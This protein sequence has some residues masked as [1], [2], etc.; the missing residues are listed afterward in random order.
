[1][2]V[3]KRKKNKNYTVLSNYHLRDKNLSLKAKGLLSI[4]LG[5]PEKWDYSTSGLETLSNDGNASVRSALQE[6][7]KH[8]YLNRDKIRDDKGRV[9]DWEYTVYENPNDNKEEEKETPHVEIPHVDNQAQ[10]NTKELNTKELK[11]YDK[12]NNSNEL[13]SLSK[14]EEMFNEFWT[15][16]PKKTDKKRTYD[17]FMKIVK[18]EF[19]FN[20]ILVGMSRTVIPQSKAEGNQ[21]VPMPSTWLNGE[22][23]NDEPYKPKKKDGLLF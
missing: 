13:L 7:E 4:M 20:D 21:Y 22:R 17:K 19:T 12:S 1:M 18:D 8:K 10:Y 3:V 11:N 16:Y 2:T 14:K 15:K 5:L 6:L 23:W 9:V